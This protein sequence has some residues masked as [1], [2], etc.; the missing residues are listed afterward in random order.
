MERLGQKSSQLATDESYDVAHLWSSNVFVDEDPVSQDQEHQEPPSLSTATRTVSFKEPPQPVLSITLSFSENETS[1]SEGV[2][3]PNSST[4]TTTPPSIPTS[5]H[6][7]EN[8]DTAEEP[9]LD[10][11]MPPVSNIDKLTLR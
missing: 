5:S 2:S 11:S 3:T 8:T 4:N 9:S 1:N 7:G 10:I 6:E